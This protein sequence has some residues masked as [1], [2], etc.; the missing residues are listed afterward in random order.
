MWFRSSGTKI[1]KLRPLVVK[2]RPSRER[3]FHAKM[4]THFV[5]GKHAWWESCG[6]VYWGRRK[7]AAIRVHLPVLELSFGAWMCFL[8]PCKSSLGWHY[9]LCSQ[10]RRGFGKSVY[11]PT[12]FAMPLFFPCYSFLPLNSLFLNCH[13]ILS[14]TPETQIFIYLINIYWIPT[15][16]WALS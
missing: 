16:Y 15:V 9:P 14:L 5:P 2:L 10:L 4:C 13:F 6:M 3:K 8:L 11:E 1:F 12:S 7:R